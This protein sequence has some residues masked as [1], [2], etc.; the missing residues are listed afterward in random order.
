METALCVD[1]SV[2]VTWDVCYVGVVLSVIDC[3]Y[4]SL[5]NTGLHV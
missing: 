2:S 5:P 1:T 4:T 3:Y